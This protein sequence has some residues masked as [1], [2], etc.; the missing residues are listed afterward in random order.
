MELLLSSVHSVVDVVIPR[1]S[2]Q[3]AAMP[4]EGVPLGRIE[5]LLVIRVDLLELLQPRAGHAQ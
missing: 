4:G 5:P 1:V 2:A 3:H